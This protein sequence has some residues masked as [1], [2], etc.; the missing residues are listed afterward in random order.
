MNAMSH[1]ISNMTDVDQKGLAEQIRQVVPGY[2][3]MG[4]HGM[5]QMGHMHMPLPPNT[6]PMMTGTGQ[7]G[8]IEM[9]GMF[10]I[11]KIRDGITNYEDPGWYKHPA[12]TTAYL[13]AEARP[14]EHGEGHG[15]PHEHS[16]MQSMPHMDVRK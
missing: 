8:P 11:I 5:G 4:A 12:G 7:F 14:A 16:P 6:L 9:G 1:A 13:V 2:M 10:T 3:P 15:K